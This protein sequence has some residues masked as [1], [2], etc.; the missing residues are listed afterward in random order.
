MRRLSTVVAMVAL[1]LSGSALAQQ[2]DVGMSVEAGEGGG[3]GKIEAGIYLGGFISNYFHQFY[4]PSLEGPEGAPTRPE[5]ERVTPQFGM[6]FAVF[7]RA[8]FGIEVD[9]SVIMAS[10]KMSSEGA[11]IY[12]LGATAILQKHLG[13]VTPY[14]G[15]GINVKHISS[16]NAVLGSDTD[17][18]IHAA[19]GARFW[20]SNA[21]AIRADARFLRGPSYPHQNNSLSNYTLN[22]SYGE[23]SLGVSFNP[24]P[25]VVAAAVVAVDPD[26]DKDGV[27]DPNDA[28]PNEHGGGN[29]DGC[30][31]RD[32]D[33]DGIPDAQDKCPDQPETFNKYQDDDGC[34]D[35]IPDTDGDGLDDLVDRCP[36]QAE[37]KDGFQDEDG[38]P[39]PDNDGDGVL[40][41]KDRCP[42]TPGPVENMGCPDTDQDGDGVVD[43]LD[44]CP[45]E[46]G[47]AANHGCKAKQLV[48]ITK[49]QLKILDTVKFVTGSAKL[50]PA[51]NKLLDNVA[52]VLLAHLEIWKVRVEGHT[53]N[54]GNPDKNMKL[55]QDR[56]QSVVNYLVKKGVAPERLEA[57]GF[58]D[59]K[60][61]EDNKSAKGRTA[62][63]RVEFNI[64][65][66]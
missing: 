62:N 36:D 53:D 39:D 12:G 20:L 60:P 47:T 38:C 50:S 19:I 41:A 5:L 40:D 24:K 58:G 49:D 45:E 11:Q 23:F 30:P 10:T 27:L 44:N 2:A 61:I 55:S 18:P 7:P 9:G 29:P 21:I 54:V 14:A 33:G 35:T 42:G 37:D 59:T 25:R 3:P 13:R 8:H 63:R 6:R 52:R 17:F 26:P 43:R 22:A 46:K 34:P 32:R 66:E 15:L 51:S 57:A 48:Q 65:S 64:V 28:C 1:G 31:T 16:D 4:D 56:A